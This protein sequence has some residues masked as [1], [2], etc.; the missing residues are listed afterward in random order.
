MRRAASRY[1][2]EFSELNTQRQIEVCTRQF[3]AERAGA[4]APDPAPIFIVGLPRSGSTLIEQ[5][6]ASHSAVE[7]TQELHDIPRIVQE[8]QQGSEPE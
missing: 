2:P 8:L 7:A 6:L 4:G 3:F 5:I 1:R